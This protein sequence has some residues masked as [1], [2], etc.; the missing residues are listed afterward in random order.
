VGDIPVTD[1]GQDA[2]SPVPLVSGGSNKESSDIYHAVVARL[3]ERWRIIDSCEPNPYRQW[4]LQHRSSLL[5]P[6]SWTAGA[7]YGSFCQT[8]AVLLRDI[9]EKAGTC[10][11]AALAIIAALPERSA[12]R[13]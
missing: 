6:D 10:D 13:P 3:N 12:A 8:R 9:R 2:E 11:P 1:I 5:K 4:I 7:P